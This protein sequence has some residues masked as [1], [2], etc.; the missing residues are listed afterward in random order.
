MAAQHRN[1]PAG[2]DSATRHYM[3]RLLLFTLAMV[4]VSA[5]VLRAQVDASRPHWRIGAAPA[6][7]HS[8]ISHADLIIASLHDALQRELAA[9]LAQGGPAFA[10]KSCHIDVA[11]VTRRIARRPGITAGRTSDRLRNPASRPPAWAAGLVAADAGRRARDIDGYAVDLGDAVGV[12]RPIVHQPM[13]T[14][15]HGPAQ[16][17][18]SRVRANLAARYPA[19]RAIGFREGELRGWFWVR[20]PKSHD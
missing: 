10:V 6:E 1:W 14:P 19:D 4:V 7:L 18:D 15:C 5:V 17:I 12:L 8:A 2:T 11:G 13:C 20:L 9:G 16:Q 3:R